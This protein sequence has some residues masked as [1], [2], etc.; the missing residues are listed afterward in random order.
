MLCS[1]SIATFRWI[2]PCPASTISC[3]AG[4]LLEHQRGIFLD[5]LGDG[6]GD[7]DFVLAVGGFDGKPIDRRA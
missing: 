3:V 4:I 6:G 2:S 1:F 7:L 5:Q